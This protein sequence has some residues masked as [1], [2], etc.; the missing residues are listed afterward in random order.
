[1]CLLSQ[2]LPEGHRGIHRCLPDLRARTKL[3]LASFIPCWFL[4]APGPTSPWTLSLACHL[5]KVTVILTVGDRFSKTSQFIA[6]PKLPTARETTEIILVFVFVF[7]LHGSDGVSDQGS[8][9]TS[10]F[11]SEFYHLLGATVSLSSGFH[12]LSNGQAECMN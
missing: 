7:R 5:L 12:P 8:Q 4:V 9:F 3:P 6:L 10:R 2:K 1:M 11:W